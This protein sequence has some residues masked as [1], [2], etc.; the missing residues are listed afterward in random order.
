M[1]KM[2]FTVGESLFAKNLQ[3]KHDGLI[4]KIDLIMLTKRRL[5]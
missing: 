4:G 2:A 1:V 5:Q 3:W